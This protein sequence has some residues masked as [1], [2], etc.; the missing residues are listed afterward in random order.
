DSTRQRMV[1]FGGQTAV[2]DT[3]TRGQL[4]TTAVASEYG[5]GCGVPPL[6]LTASSS[7]RP[8]IGQVASATIGNATSS[9][10]AIAIGLSRDQYG[11]FAQPVTI[12]RIGMPGCDL[13]QS[14][15]VLG[16]FATSTGPS[17]LVYD[18]SLPNNLAIVGQSIY[19]QAYS[20]A[21]GANQLEAVA[22][23]GLEW[24]IGDL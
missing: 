14:S 15:D 24:F 1:M 16:L 8:V 7:G 12:A 18:Q 3:W 21:P 6:T 17:T 22:S 10:A 2:S 19:L 11:P 23:N 13:L 4:G 5:V 9:I 20:F